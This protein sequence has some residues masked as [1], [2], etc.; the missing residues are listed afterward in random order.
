MGA[1][2]YDPEIGR[3][4]SPDTIVPDPSSPQQFNRFGYVSNNPVKYTDPTGHCQFGW[5]DQGN[6][7]ITKDDCTVDE[8]ESLDWNQRILW[9]MTFA[10]MH[11]L[12]SWFNDIT[13]VLQYFRDDPDFSPAGGWAYRA[14]AAVLQAIQDGW[15]M[16][17]GKDPVGY[18]DRRDRHQVHGGE[19]WKTFFE[20][21]AGPEADK[22][23]DDADVLARL[24]AE[25]RGADY[26]WYVGR[27]LYEAE[28]GR[29]QMKIRMFKNAADWY[30]TELVPWHRQNT[31]WARG[32]IFDPRTSGGV[33]GVLS[34]SLSAFH[35]FIDSVP[36]HI[37]SCY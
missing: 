34:P 32:G 23:S 11:R 16:F 8:F 21:V 30:R 27:R 1:R 15:R 9:L 31:Q 26:A 7:I 37:G 13:T 17:E 22:S 25:Q 33:V 36:C 35:D 4:I 18:Y 5:D 3:W 19:N 20:M 10:G 12:G 24:A 29:S 6:L 28:D 14:D 2:W